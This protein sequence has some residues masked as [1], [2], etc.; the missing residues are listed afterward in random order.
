[1]IHEALAVKLALFFVIDACAYHDLLS[2]SL[3]FQNLICNF[4][5]GFIAC[6][7]FYGIKHLIH[8]PLDELPAEICER[9]ER[10][11]VLNC[12]ERR[13]LIEAQKA[14]MEA[15][16]ERMNR[17][18]DMLRFKSWYYAQAIRDGNEDAIPAMIPAGLP[19]DVR[20]AYENA[21]REPERNAL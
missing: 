9:R 18:L 19:E 13:A 10:F 14:H 7:N 17:A 4:T 2:G 16:I 5:N 11:P 21:H 20:R 6:I 1:M 8:S 3:K 15:E 12:R